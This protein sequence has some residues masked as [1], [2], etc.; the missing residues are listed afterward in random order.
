MSQEDGFDG[1]F[2]SLDSAMTLSVQPTQPAMAQVG[3]KAALD[4]T[5]RDVEFGNLSPVSG[6]VAPFPAPDPSSG[7]GGSLGGAALAGGLAGGASLAALAA[8]SAREPSSVDRE[9]GP[10]GIGQPGAGSEAAFA[11]TAAGALPSNTQERPASASSAEQGLESTASVPEEDDQKDEMPAGGPILEQG[12][13]VEQSVPFVPPKSPEREVTPM[14]PAAET[15]VALVAETLDGTPLNPPSPTSSSSP[16]D[17]D[18]YTRKNTLSSLKSASSG[19][20]ALAALAAAGAVASTLERSSPSPEN[21]TESD[22]RSISSG[23]SRTSRYLP[24][25]S[26]RGTLRTIDEVI[27]IIDERTGHVLDKKTVTVTEYE[28]DMSVLEAQSAKIEI[29]GAEIVG[30]GE[31]VTVEYADAGVAEG[32]DGTATVVTTITDLKGE[33][34]T[35]V[36]DVSSVKTRTSEDASSPA[37]IT[38][39]PVP[40]PLPDVG[41]DPLQRSPSIQSITISPVL[42]NEETISPEGLE[43]PV[44]QPAE[45]AAEPISTQSPESPIMHSES[46]DP[47]ES[48]LEETKSVDSERTI[49]RPMGSLETIVPTVVQPPEDLTTTLPTAEAQE[50]PVIERE[51]VLLGDQSQIVDHQLD[52]NLSLPTYSR[53]TSPT[54][55]SPIILSGGGTRSVRGATDA[56]RRSTV[57]SFAPPDEDDIPDLSAYH[58]PAPTSHVVINHYYPAR[59]DEM[60]MQVG[61]LVGIEREYTDGWARGQNITHGRKRGF[62]PLNILTPIKSGPSQRVAKIGG[63]SWL[64]RAAKGDDIERRASIVPPPRDTSLPTRS[65]RSTI[66]MTPILEDD[67]PPTH[68]ITQNTAHT[69]DPDGTTIETTTTV[70]RTGDSPNLLT[71]IVRRASK[72]NGDGTVTKR[73]SVSIVDVVEETGDGT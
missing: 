58:P 37:S 54:P 12:N 61:D 1:Q 23:T 9:T 17:M 72:R 24:T 34:Q 11:V 64:G 57:L 45:E 16:W 6:N 5:A 35:L 10:N 44:V 59:P 69:H 27:T 2:S 31:T 60:A 70:T 65:R 18:Q 26:R 46:N 21:A 29:A 42:S 67:D 50:H 8:L 19:A 20:G 38:G 25:L 53:P 7:A 41:G 55:L 51:D 30:V 63:R 40:D 3:T 68:L 33:T 66:D 36:S 52:P 39:V 73:V 71:R 32:G 47:L 22:G 4:N 48:H 15:P 49:I 14:A 56:S 13:P 62:F 43:E 28:G